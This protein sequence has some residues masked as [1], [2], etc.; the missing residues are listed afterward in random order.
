MDSND[1][2][3]E[4]GI[5]ISSKSTSLLWLNPADGETYQINIVDTPGH[6]DFGGEVERIMNMVD[7]VALLVDA[8]EGPMTQT[9]FV[10]SKA[11]EKGL[12]PFV[13][14]NKADKPSNRIGIVEGEIFDLFDSLGAT[15]EQL[16]FPFL[17]TSAKDSWAVRDISHEK[18]ANMEEVFRSIVEHIPPPHVDHSQP[19]FSM[20]VSQIDTH[21]FF[22]TLLSGRVNTGTIRA[23]IHVNALDMD[24]KVTEA[25]KVLKIFCRRGMEQVEVHEAFAGDIVSLAGFT[26]ATVNHTLC[27]PEIT[28]PIPTQPIDPPTISMVFSTNTSPLAGKGGGMA[29]TAG[30]IKSRLE[31][32]LKTNVSLR[33]K[34]VPSGDAF[35]VYGRGELQLGI[36]IETMRR[37]GF[38]LSVSAPRVIFHRDEDNVLVEPIEDLVIDIE[39]EHVPGIM[40]KLFSRK[41]EMVNSSD[42]DSEGRT[43]FEFKVPTRGIIGFRAEFVQETRANGVMNHAFSHY[44]AHKGEIQR[45]QKGALV[46]HENGKTSGY[47][48]LACEPRGTM[49]VGVGEDCYEGMIVGEASRGNDVI[50]NPVKT[51]QLT[52]FRAAG[53]DDTVKLKPHRKLSLEEMLSYVRDDEL[54]EVTPTSIR[55]RKACLDP[56]ERRRARKQSK[57]EQQV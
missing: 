17:Y 30:L 38:E 33:M 48:L 9:R 7:G 32:E 27:N 8:T 28:E 40:E 3:K 22:D 19:L 54:I 52:N 18:K 51:K 53:K 16:D 45:S 35:E 2:E 49:F 4:R 13:V 34:G 6:A 1:L 25:T 41:A 21:P 23:G 24:G 10:L 37:E 14:F 55:L 46:G 56:N 44:E 42:P 47:G 57:S 36:L 11:L 26:K 12:Q 31:N 5:T 15:D 50:V 29:V 43:K 20:L 39:Q